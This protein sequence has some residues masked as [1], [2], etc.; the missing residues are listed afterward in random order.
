MA[1]QYISVPEN[2]LSNGIDSRSSENQIAP[3]FVQDLLNADIIEKRVRKRTGYV[4]YGG[5]FPTR[6]TQLDYVA[7]TNTAIFTLDSGIS[8]DSAVSLT[9]VKSSPLVI[10]G[11]TNNLPTGPFTE[12]DSAKYYPGFLVPVRKELTAPS[13]TLVIQG[14]EHG[15][16][17]TDILVSVVEATDSVSTSYSQILTDS[18][19][20]NSSNFN[21]SIGY[22]VPASVDTF[23]YYQNAT[24]AAGTSYLAVFSHTGSGSETLAIPAGT[25]N[26]T[27]LNIIPQIQLIA[28]GVAS[29]VIPDM[30][31]VAT[32]GTI[33]VQITAHSAST[34]HV[35]LTAAPA[36]QV[37]SGVVNALSSGTVVLSNLS[38]D[39]VFTGIYLEQTPGGTKELVYPDSAV[40]DS[41]LKEYTLT[42]QNPAATARNFIVYYS[43]GS[44]RSNRLEVIDSSVTVDGTDTNPQLTIWGLVQQEIYP[45]KFAREGWVN[46]IDIY[47]QPGEE[48]VVAGLGGNEFAVREFQEAASAYL[49]PTLVP[50]LSGR[51]SSSVILGPTFY[52]TGDT[53]ARTRGYITA[54]G[55][56]TNW[57]TCTAITYNPGTG[58]TDYTLTVPNKQVLN[59]AGVP[60]SLGSVITTDDF[61]LIQGA[62]YTRHEGE[63]P[64]Q[65]VSDGVNSITISVQLPDN[66]SDYNDS[67]LAAEVGIF[68][69][70]LPLS[71]ISS[72]I[73]EDVL[74]SSALGV[75]PLIVTSSSGS[76]VT[77][78]GNANVQEVP[79]G[80]LIT[81]QRTSSVVPLRTSNPNGVPSVTNL[82]RGDMVSYT[83]TAR[84]LRCQVV[85]SS[86]NN[87]GSVASGILTY[88]SGDTSN[89][90][91]GQKLL[92][93][94]A[95]ACTGVATVISVDS[96]TQVTTDLTTSCV[97][98][99]VAGY[100][101]Q[102]D[103]EFT[104]SELPG[105]ATEFQVE[106][107]WIPIEA[108]DDSFN[109]TPSTHTRYFDT[110]S[111]SD[112]PYARSC[113]VTDSLFLSNYSDP[114]YKIDGTSMYRAGLPAWQPGLFLTQET[115]NTTPRIVI[116]NRIITY[117][118]SPVNAGGY[119]PIGVN[120]VNTLP[121]G[122]LV[123]ISGST[124]TY[125]VTSYQEV[126]AGTSY[127]ILFDRALDSSVSAT[128]TIAEIADFHYY[129]RLNAVD[130]NQNVI[131][132]AAV[133]SSDYVVE[134][135]A[136]AGINIKLVGLPV[137]DT[138]DYARLEVQI[139]R[140]KQGQ[141]AP[142]YLVTTIPMSFNNT[143]GYIQYLDSF[144]DSDLTQL[145]PVQ[146]VLAGKEIGTNW[147]GPL[148]AKHVTSVGNRLYLA[149]LVGTPTLDLQMVGNANLAN[150]DIAGGTLLFRRDDTDPGTTTDM[151]NRV[152]YEWKNGFTGDAS[153]FSIGT[154]QFSF[155]TSGS[156]GCSPGDWIYLTYSTVATTGRLLTYC[157]WWQVAAC[158]GTTVTVNLTGAAASSTYPD[159]YTVATATADVPVLLGVDGSLG[160]IDGDIFD[161][162]SAMRRMGLAISATQRMVDISLVPDFTPWL[163]T[164]SGNDV[165]PAGRL[166]V[167]QPNITTQTISITP[168]FSNYS[169]FINQ[170]KRLT[171]TATSAST[172]AYPSR[173]MASFENYPE[174]F[175]SPEVVLDVDSNSAIDVNSADGQEITGIITFFGDATFIAAQQAAII[176]VFKTN[177]I[178]L[179]NLDE[180]LA[181]R[182]PVQKIETEGLGC[183]APY[184]IAATKKGI[185]FANHSGMYCLRKDLTLDYLGKFMER[186][187]VERVD[188]TN[189]LVAQGHHYGV[190]RMYKLSVP[191]AD[192]I[193]P[194]TGYVENSEVFVYN[195]TAEDT[196]STAGNTVLMNRTGA[197][198]RYDNHPATGW[199]NFNSD[200]FFASTHGRVFKL[201]STGLTSDFRDDAGPVDM[202][203]DSRFNDFGNPGIRKIVDKVII[204]YRTGQTA[205]GTLL[206]Y[207]IDT[208]REYTPTT[209]FQLTIPAVTTGTDDFV[210]RKV[211]NVRHSV[212]RRKCIYMAI[213]IENGMIDE[214]IE[215]ANI[216]YVVGGLTAKGITEA[217]QTGAK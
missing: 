13:G 74:L 63:F 20:I 116:S 59:S 117:S 148:R 130:A 22:T 78:R 37:S 162:F 16:L 26:L 81:G 204:S 217:A 109:L 88:T 151:T 200:A 85:N 207:A 161:T 89:I 1:V 47:R 82:V 86:S 201:R 188:L 182:N 149:N 141:A 164:R 139:Y 177:S 91:P 132:S 126:V 66:S 46:H 7:A 187:W 120:N 55:S 15:I 25:H 190:G 125:T 142:F 6:V 153:A 34:Y 103:E 27:N 131:A 193:N 158:T 19:T 129:F 135:T 106:E 44:V 40:F 80:V 95:G 183:T 124:E 199:V 79:A 134:L 198:G 168:V 28:G 173:I 128:G 115:S 108:P 176:V 8:L 215:I 87:T 48:R 29:T 93:L 137:F 100:T 58:L 138:Y 52:A 9:S 68:T 33:S 104:W 64:I 49:Y 38:K 166:V 99:I 107:R 94:N 119:I 216:E 214:N 24:P 50:N 96:T 67:G 178:Y 202:V 127:N 72:F 54:D 212:G 169:L 160:M 192:T 146:S 97:S 121:V 77:C 57:V 90:L 112:Q 92:L 51:V 136:D 31:T 123:R 175:D 172:P 185:L 73:P 12:T 170:I 23:V 196:L 205:T 21:I 157:G 174:I 191:I 171:S 180:K 110:N 11:R 113:M 163:I 30:F 133:Q 154:N 101:V 211:V 122:T 65:A 41:T 189:L 2:D 4:G 209:P 144:A 75:A 42:F 36:A 18:L 45:T 114:V 181:G 69:D 143:T 60:T 14:S 159:K 61:L 194:A 167:H 5:D 184:S 195:H 10:F 84:Q 197:W 17:N 3:G 150:S 206:S 210:S 213:R 43:Y 102:L 62:G 35:L 39:W 32:N 179:I 203:V 98:C 152:K 186:N 165:T 147:S 76:S 83:S 155:T 70:T 105:D 56:G 111:Y 53:P 208:E 140:T 145:D 71:A 156:T 118:S